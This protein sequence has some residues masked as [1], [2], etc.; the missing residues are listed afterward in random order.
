MAYDLFNANNG[1]KTFVLRFSSLD[2]AKV[3][4]IS[5]FGNIVFEE[6]DGDCIDAAT[7]RGFTICFE[8]AN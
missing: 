4:A 5:A 7:D 6:E 8:P 3:H 1:H 2:A